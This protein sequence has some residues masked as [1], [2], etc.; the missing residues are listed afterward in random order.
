[1][2]KRVIGI[3][4]VF[5]MVV[6]NI[7]VTFAA[8]ASQNY[9]DDKT[10]GNSSVSESKSVTV[11]VNKPLEIA[12]NDNGRIKPIEEINSNEKK[13]DE[14]S[15]ESS[16]KF[17]VVSQKEVNIEKNFSEASKLIP[18]YDN[19]S[20]AST[21]AVTASLCDIIVYDLKRAAGQPSP[22]VA[23]NDSD[24]E[25]TIANIG[26][27]STG[28]FTTGIKIDNILMG[29]FTV[30][31]LASYTGVVYTITLQQVPEG[32]HTVQ[33]IGDYNNAITES[34]ETNNTASATFQWVGTPNLKAEFLRADGTSPFEV[35]NGVDFT[36]RVSNNGNGKVNGN[37]SIE[38]RVNGSVLATWTVT[39]WPAQTYLED[40]FN[41]IFNQTGTYT[42]EMR[43][44]PYN[45]VAES[46]ENDNI[47]S[48]SY[49]VVVAPQIRVRGYV[50]PSFR[51]SHNTGATAI[52][53][54]LKG[55]KV[56]IMDQDILFND[57]LAT[58]YTD[59]NGYFDVYVNNQP[60]ENGV[61]LFIKLEFDDNV[62]DIKSS[63]LFA[64]P[65]SWES[66]IRPDIQ[67]GDYNFGTLSLSNLPINLEGAFSIWY[68]VK[69]GNDY[70]A[71]NSSNSS[72]IPKVHVNW[73]DGV[74]TGAYHSGSTIMIGGD[75]ADAACFDADVILH[76]YGHHVMAYTAGDVPGAGGTHTYT[77]PSSLATAYSE[78]WAHFFSCSVRN[79]DRTIDTNPNGWFGANLETPAYITSGGT[80][81]ATPLVSN[82]EENAKYELNVGAV[83]WDLR[84]NVQDGV[85]TVSHSFSTVDNVMAGN[86]SRHV[87]DYYNRWFATSG[88]PYSKETLWNV[89]ESRKCSYDL[90]VPTVSMSTN[91]TTVYASASD[92]IAVKKYEWYVDGSYY[93]QGNGSTGTLNGSSL[94]PGFHLVEFR[95]YD[96]E[97]LNTFSINPDGSNSRPRVDRYGSSTTGIYITGSSMQLNSVSSKDELL[98][99]NPRKINEYHNTLLKAVPN[100]EKIIIDKI[101]LL[102]TGDVSK[103]TVIVGKN[104]DLKV[105]S[106]IVGMMKNISIYAPDGTLYKMY[107]YI[108]PDKPVIIKNAQPGE[109][110]IEFAYLTQKDM[111]K[112][113]ANKDMPS[114]TSTPISLI[115]TTVPS[116]VDFELPEITNNAN[117]IIDLLGKNL[118]DSNIKIYL[119]GNYVKDGIVKL[120][121]GINKI[122]MERVKDN[123]TSG[124]K[125]YL[126]TLDTIAPEIKLYNQEEITTSDKEVLIHGL[127]S[128]DVESF[129]I[130]GNNVQISEFGNGFAQYYALNDGI[131][132]F[133]ISATD[134]AG[135]KSEKTVTVFKK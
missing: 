50:V 37:C 16:I 78:A 56:K 72:S 10:K 86:N 134:K 121:E 35:G 85:D 30:S 6:S 9:N 44:D 36:F 63:S 49:N 66:T 29:S 21:N 90:Q 80:N 75:H 88:S 95:A 13:V 28:N 23:L 83:L 53:T 5:L 116:T 124:Q 55:F 89:F 99:S 120:K 18:T 34:D 126:I 94:S 27:A 46:N 1:M 77:S 11:K 42:V 67:V 59:S 65:Y 107:D 132:K 33:I 19:N 96:P 51:Y 7:S 43:A 47:V 115:I 14:K 26:T 70:Y 129:V 117:F 131:N 87:Y 54:P 119:D 61:D 100:N 84:D 123:F 76:E 52:A 15:S 69:K 73:E 40:S 12:G 79:S 135:N 3:L 109:W 22:F 20:E 118:K 58:V 71:Q 38:L 133:S 105:Y 17:K 112:Y 4:L 93:S 2:T 91:G 97:G 39:D 113:N 92:N 110:N 102:N 82:Y 101:D 128:N 114:N 81:S 68:W 48:N 127:C 41:L 45:Y 8:D 111:E 24:I 74:G 125:D 98:T 60:S 130:N 103:Y 25:V 31:S 122:S 104:E 108:S 64:T 106:H 62:M 32:Y 57:E